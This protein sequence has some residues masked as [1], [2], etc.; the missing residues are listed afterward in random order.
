MARESGVEK[1][2]KRE[3]VSLDKFIEMPILEDMQE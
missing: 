1:A 2:N 3:V